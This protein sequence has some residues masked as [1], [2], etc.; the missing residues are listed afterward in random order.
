MMTW[1]RFSGL[2]SQ[3]VW[4][5]KNHSSGFI[6]VFELKPMR[7]KAHGLL[8]SVP[9]GLNS[10]GNLNGFNGK[11][12]VGGIEA[13]ALTFSLFGLLPSFKPCGAPFSRSWA[14]GLNDT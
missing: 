3:T 9:Q 5:Q 6:P 12:W 11:K 13:L 2:S 8:Q 4:Q 10:E 7:R 14:I 1:T